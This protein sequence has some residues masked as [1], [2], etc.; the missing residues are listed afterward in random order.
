MAAMAKA[1]PEYSQELV[2]VCVWQDPKYLG[3][4]LLFQAIS[5]ELDLSLSI[6]L[7]LCDSDFQ[8]K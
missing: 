7:S 2:I 5:K 8:V 1:N 3:H 6:S 4:L